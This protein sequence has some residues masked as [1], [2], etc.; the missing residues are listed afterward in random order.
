SAVLALQ[1]AGFNVN[2]MINREFN[3]KYDSGIVFKTSPAGKAK[4][5]KGSQ[6]DIWVSKGTQQVAVPV[7]VHLTQAEAVAK[8]E[9]LGLVPNV[10]GIPDP[11]PANPSTG[12]VLTQNPDAGTMVNVG[13]TVKIYV[14]NP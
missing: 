10:Q 13:S 9:A 11:D 5:A 1:A 7:L 2:P 12:I 4:A 14:V 8:L 6:V 3:S